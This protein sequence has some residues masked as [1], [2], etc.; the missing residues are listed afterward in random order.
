GRNAHPLNIARFAVGLLLVAFVLLAFGGIQVAIA[1][2]FALM[3]GMANGLITI[4]RGAVPLALFGP[5][6]YGRNIGLI[7]R[8]WMVVQASAPLALAFVIEHASDGIA[9]AVVAMFAAIAFALLMTIR[10][11][12]AG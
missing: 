10:P 12:A 4:A 1:G 6:G 9:L 7:A 11:P 2:A 5:V 3:F 8:P